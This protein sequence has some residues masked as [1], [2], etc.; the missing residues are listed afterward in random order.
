MEYYAINDHTIL[1]AMEAGDAAF[2]AEAERKRAI[3]PAAFAAAHFLDLSPAALAFLYAKCGVAPQA[4]EADLE[5]AAPEA[6]D[7]YIRSG[8]KIPPECLDYFAVYDLPKFELL[9]KY[10]LPIP[11]ES[12]A[13]WRFPAHLPALRLYLQYGGT[14]ELA[15]PPDNPGRPPK[16][17]VDVWFRKYGECEAV[18]LLRQAG[19][20]PAPEAAMPPWPP[21]SNP[22]TPAWGRIAALAAEAARLPRTAPRLPEIRQLVDELLFDIDSPIPPGD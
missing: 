6:V 4:T 2:L 20:R 19:A 13:Q 7:V 16:R 12:A 3:T 15:I 18:R 11:P 9:L 21:A 5:Y 8:G 22:N 10:G 17:L 1:E 14:P